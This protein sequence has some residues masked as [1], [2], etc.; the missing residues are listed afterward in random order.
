MGKKPRLNNVFFSNVINRIRLSLNLSPYDNKDIRTFYSTRSVVFFHAHLETER[1]FRRAPH[2][3]YFYLRLR[4]PPLLSRTV[5]TVSGWLNYIPGTCVP[6]PFFQIYLSVP[7]IR[8]SPP[9]YRK[10]PTKLFRKYLRSS[11]TRLVFF[12]SHSTIGHSCRLSLSVGSFRHCCGTTWICI[13]NIFAI[14]MVY[15]SSVF[16]VVRTV[17]YIILFVSINTRD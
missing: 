10:E 5:I 13:E 6:S 4:T 8:P 12:V 1:V 16:A 9:R 14:K 7:L 3:Y 2:N 15:G 11:I 17:E